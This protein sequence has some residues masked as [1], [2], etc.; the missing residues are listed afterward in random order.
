MPEYTVHLIKPHPKQALIKYHTAKRKI[1]RAGRRGGKT[2]LA[3]EISVDQ[4]LDGHRVL[5]AVPTSDQ[6][7]K[8]W[9][10]VTTA[11][12]EPIEAGVYHVNRSTH[13]IEVPGTENRIRG[14]T[15]WNAS[16]LRGD[17][18]DYLILDEVQLMSEDTWDEVGAPMLLDN[19]GDAM[20][21]YTPPSIRA[22]VISRAQDKRWIAKLF[23]AKSLDKTG[24]WACFHFTSKD[25]PHISVEALGE[26][27]K[28][29]TD[30]AYRQEILAED[31]EEAP[32]ALWSR[33]MIEDTRVGQRPARLHRI[34]VGVDPALS[35]EGNEAGII[36]GGWN[37]N[38][39]EPHY[40]VTDDESVQGTPVEWAKAVLLLY[41]KL[42]ADFIILE[43]NAGGEMNE[44]TLRLAA[45]E[46]VKAKLIPNIY[47]RVQY[48]DAT[49]NKQTRADPISVMYANGEVH[50]VGALTQLEDELCLW[51]PSSANSPNRLDALVWMLWALKEGVGGNDLAGAGHVED[52]VN[53]WK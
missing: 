40:F 37:G 15:A 11:L 50:H 1:V 39:E 49:R 12:K 30:I 22:S 38:V 9:Y 45:Q 10:E 23:K 36:G 52:Y 5:Y 32:G 25:N 44:V 18:A 19:D 28:D 41:H 16:T 26:I 43:K 51:T 42:Q 33:K 14:K 48:V 13:S 4:F 7:Q 21:I 53:R 27:S 29:M 34:C 8:W 3:A 6:L 20:F 46:L 35:S 2:T 31:I 47:F 24:R 17:Y